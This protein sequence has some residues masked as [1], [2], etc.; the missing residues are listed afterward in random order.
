MSAAIPN[1]ESMERVGTLMRRAT[2][3]SISVAGVLVAVKLG[4]WVETNSVSLLSSL[5]DSL[6]DGAASLANLI[7]VRQA[8]VPPDR[9]H[10]F[11]HGKAEPLASLGQAAFIAGSALLLLIEA[12][13]HLIH[14]QPITNTV[15]GLAVMVFAVVTT[16]VLVLY[17]RSVV[18]RTGSLVVSVDAFH[19]RADL[20]LNLA[21]IAAL[22]LTV[23]FG[24]VLIDPIFGGLIA[25]WIIWGAWQV[26]NR[27]IVQLMDRELPDAERERIRAIALAHPEVRAVHDMKTRAAGPVSFIQIHLEMDG[28]LPLTQAHRIADEVEAKI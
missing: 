18:K 2:Y 19:Y 9:E 6:L 20:V 10:R 26:A 27:A 25:L 4:A 23:E 22:L 5:I 1:Q 7:A 17:Q 13:Q 3:A 15:A 12:I 14:P 24:D 28:N 8:L 16:L 21:V 11:G